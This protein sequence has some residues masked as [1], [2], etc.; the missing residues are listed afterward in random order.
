MW[1]SRGLSF[2]P[3]ISPNILTWSTYNV[4]SRFCIFVWQINTA[5]TEFAVIALETDCNHVNYRYFA[6]FWTE[7]ADWNKT[8]EG[9]IFGEEAAGTLPFVNCRPLLCTRVGD[10][11]KGRIN[12]SCLSTKARL[13]AHEER[14]RTV[15]HSWTAAI[16]HIRMVSLLS[17][18]VVVDRTEGR[19][20]SFPFLRSCSKILLFSTKSY[21]SK[22]VLYLKNILPKFVNRL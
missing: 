6:K 2:S 7:Q 19:L 1:Y 9:K 3:P 14:S 15:Y 20:A 10:E 16:K 8:R 21:A 12:Y 22:T 18:V 13:H 5:D 4:T 11:Q 17:T